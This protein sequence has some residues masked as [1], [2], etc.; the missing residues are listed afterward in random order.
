MQ[1]SW[2][3]FLCLCIPAVVSAEQHPTNISKDAKCGTIGVRY[4]KFHK[5]GSTTMSNTIEAYGN[6]YNLSLCPMTDHLE[7]LKMCQI[8][9]THKASLGVLSKF[10]LKT[11]FGTVPAGDITVVLLR[12]PRERALSLY[13]FRLA[14]HNKGTWSG[15]WSE[16]DALQFPQGPRWVSTEYVGK[17]DKGRMSVR[18]TLQR[19]HLFH[20][21]GITENMTAAITMLVLELHCAAFA[22]VFAYQNVKVVIGRPTYNDVPAYIQLR[23]DA[24]TKS[25][26]QV[27]E[28]ARLL[29]EQRASKYNPKEFAG[30]Y[31]ELGNGVFENCGLLDNRSALNSGMECLTLER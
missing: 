26:T 3:V 6:T 31:G 9:N 15:N 23:I 30:V 2:A 29:S 1:R 7:K 5:V 22:R 4:V 10:S 24:A 27:Y 18:H 13:F 20:V 12:E 21:I 11:W 16:M 17:L 19:I 8:A 14:W 25:D 28:G